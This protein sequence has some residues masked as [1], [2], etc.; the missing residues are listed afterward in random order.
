[1][2]HSRINVT[3]VKFN[4]EH[5]FND[6]YTVVFSW[7]GTFLKFGLLYSMFHSLWMQ[8]MY[9]MAVIVCHDSTLFKN[10]LCL[11]NFPQKHGEK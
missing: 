8:L 10:K 7:K 2:P 6:F 9:D 5:Q 11:F 3:G 4:E 1:M